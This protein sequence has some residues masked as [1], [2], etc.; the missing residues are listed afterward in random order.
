[1]LLLM[2]KVLLFGSAYWESA[3]KIR[4][5]FL[6]IT[7]WKW[8]SPTSSH[9]WLQGRGSAVFR[10]KCRYFPKGQVELWSSRKSPDLSPAAAAKHRLPFPSQHPIHGWSC[11]EIFLSK[12]MIWSTWLALSCDQPMGRISQEVLVTLKQGWGTSDQLENWPV[13]VGQTFN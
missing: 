13:L 9:R 10:T 6:W 8:D 3:I 5:E 7:S 1:M 4:P 11:Q 12:V 2:Q